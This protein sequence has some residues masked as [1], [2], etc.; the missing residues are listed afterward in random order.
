MPFED[1]EKE[2]AI[3]S[4]WE[5]TPSHWLNNEKEIT[6]ANNIVNIFDDKYEALKDCD[7]LLLI[8]EWSE[9]RNP[10]FEQMKVLLKN[11]NQK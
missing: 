3:K 8:T 5:G 2:T 6:C 1:G 11:L 9:F 10:D 4:D 7:C